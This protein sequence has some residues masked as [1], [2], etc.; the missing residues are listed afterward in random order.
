MDIRPQEEIGPQLRAIGIDPG[1]VRW[2][3]LTHLH[4]DHAGGLA[5][6][7]QA[8]V[9]VARRE[10]ESAKRVDG[11]LRGYLPQHWPSLVPATPDRVPRRAG[12][13][14]PGQLAAHPGGDVLLVP[15]HGHT[16]GHLSV[17]I[18]QPAQATLLL[19]GDASYRQDL[20][21]SGTI[22]G[23]A[24]DEPAAHAT[25]ERLQRFVRAEPTVF[26][27]A[28]DPGSGERFAGHRRVASPDVRITSHDPVNCRSPSPALYR[29]DPPMRHAQAD[30]GGSS[31]LAG[32]D[33]PGKRTAADK[34]RFSGQPCA[35][36]G[37]YPSERS[38]A[39]SP[40]P[41]SRS[42]RRG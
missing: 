16:H 7:P 22:D 26:L 28:H 12:R 31:D 14:V 2:V 10:Y 34:R 20:M 29:T 1:Q 11:R 18:R 25:L 39:G 41:G 38:S 19:A 40:G 13:A 17:V 8:E 30:E 24:I 6:F 32:A 42:P 33:L 37:R 35:R 3:V 15:S 9:V 36:Y 27:P 4:P 23:V 21:L 5:F